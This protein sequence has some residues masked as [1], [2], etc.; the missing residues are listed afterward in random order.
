MQ[1]TLALHGRLRREQ[2]RLLADNVP[3]LVVGT[4]VLALGAA[5]P[6]TAP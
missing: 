1:D 2:I 6:A 3:A 5:A 4:L